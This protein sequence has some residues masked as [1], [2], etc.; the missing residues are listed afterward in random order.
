MPET[1]ATK[2]FMVSLLLQKFD[3]LCQKDIIAETDAYHPSR[4]IQ[5]LERL[6][7]DAITPQ[8]RTELI[9]HLAKCDYCR[10]ELLMLIHCDALFDTEV[11]AL[12]NPRWQHGAV[13]STRVKRI[14]LTAASCAAL[15]LLAVFLPFFMR[16]NSPQQLA[17]KELAGLLTQD[18]KNISSQ[19]TE[20]GYRLNGTKYTKSLS[21]MDERKEKIVSLYEQQIAAEPENIANRMDYAKFLIYSLRDTEKV[22]A[23]LTAAISATAPTDTTTLVAL[24]TLLG[25]AE[26]EAGNDAA[27]IEQFRDVLKLTPTNFSAKLNL[28]IA[29]YRNGERAE[30]VEI[31][32]EMKNESIPEGLKK[33]IETLL[34]KSND[35]LDKETNEPS[36]PNFLEGLL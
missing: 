14:W 21:E 35:S 26:F 3:K 8:E 15:V 2:K 28:G 33:E 23:L 29:F 18:E 6:D 31:F 25:Q 36:T 4:D 9:A 24:H 13:S 27:A 5:F 34:E 10:E 19:L 12:T 11:V 32:E 20:N 30:A 7:A 22:K 16:G 1:N 17:M